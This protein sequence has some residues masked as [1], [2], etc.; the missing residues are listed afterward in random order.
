MPPTPT[1]TQTDL[2]SQT[3]LFLC[4]VTTVTIS[5]KEYTYS[6]CCSNHTYSARS[7]LSKT[8][9]CRRAAL[10]AWG[11]APPVPF[12][13][14]LSR[15]KPLFFSFL[16]EISYNNLLPSSDEIALILEKTVYKELVILNLQYRLVQDIYQE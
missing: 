2:C 13:L 5:F 8:A 12:S 6:T 16:S 10:T 3:C 14:G 4:R 7:Q 11:T 15:W 9:S 1:Q